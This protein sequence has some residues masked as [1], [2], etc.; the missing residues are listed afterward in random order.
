MSHVTD[1]LILNGHTDKEV[2]QALEQMGF[3][4]VHSHGGG[5]KVCQGDVFLASFNYLDSDDRWATRSDNGLE[6]NGEYN[7]WVAVM[8]LPWRWSSGTYH[9][10]DAPIMFVQHED[11]DNWHPWLPVKR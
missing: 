8:R 7:L 1:I 10:A 9:T 6:M 2:Q 11:D 4:D 5:N 3:I